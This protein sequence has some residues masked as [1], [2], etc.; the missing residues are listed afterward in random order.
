LTPEQQ[1]RLRDLFDA[2]LEQPS[3]ARAE[4]LAAACGTDL[5]LLHAV[6]KLLQS[7]ERAAGILDTLSGSALR[8]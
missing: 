7:N 1:R 6:E 5:D 3:G 8:L 2:A 4:F